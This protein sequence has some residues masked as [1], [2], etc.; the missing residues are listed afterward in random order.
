MNDGPF[1][2][3]WEKRKIEQFMNTLSY[4]LPCKYCRASFTK[5]SQSL[6]ITPFLDNNEK[7]E[8]LIKM[9]YFE[10]FIKEIVELRTKSFKSQL[11]Y[12]ERVFKMIDHPSDENTIKEYL[13]NN[14][15]MSMDWC[16]RFKVPI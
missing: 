5:Y 2:R 8:S 4:I 7:M 6:D 9:E 10:E 11:E 3:N 12:L 13:K 14:I 1:G 15:K 16:I